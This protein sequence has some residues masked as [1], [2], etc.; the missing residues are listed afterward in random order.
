MISPS[1]LSKIVNKLF[2]VWEND[3]AAIRLLS[4]EIFGL[5]SRLL[6]VIT[7]LCEV[8]RSMT[9]RFAQLNLVHLLSG[10]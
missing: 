10:S 9:S 2:L 3:T 4:G 6:D 1:S 8:V 5:Y 7:F